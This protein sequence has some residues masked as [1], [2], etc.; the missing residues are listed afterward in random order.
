MNKKGFTITELI[1]VMTLLAIIVAI[2]FPNFSSLTKKAKS[3]YDSSTKVFLKNAASMYV[4]NNTSEV[5][6]YLQTNSTLCVPI[7]KLIA[8]EYLDSDLK[9]SSGNALNE[10]QCINIT[11]TTTNGKTKYNYNVDNNDTVS[12]STDYIPPVISFSN[13]TGESNCSSFMNITATT[14]A[15]IIS[16]FKSKCEI[17]VRDNIDTSLTANLKTTIKNKKL[18]LEYNSADTAGNKAIPLKITLV[19]PEVITGT[20]QVLINEDYLMSSAGLIS[21]IDGRSF[22][23]TNAGDAFIGYFYI[24]GYTGPILVSENPDAVTYDTLGNVFPYST[25]IVY[26]DKTYYVSNTGYFMAGHIT[27]TSGPALKLSND[28]LTLEAAAEQLLE[29]AYGN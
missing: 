9:D 5:D 19:A 17:Q 2:S 29:K 28:D 12:A 14:K 13:K 23:K 20:N 18:F 15:S 27:P 26:N 22:N 8:Y 21:T 6:T 1:A 7:G 3:N 25:T 4:N 11:K 16:E 10:R 24:N